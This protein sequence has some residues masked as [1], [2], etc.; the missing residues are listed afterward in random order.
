MAAYASLNILYL[1]VHMKLWDVYSIE[2]YPGPP[3]QSF[4]NLPYTDANIILKNQIIRDAQQL[5]Q[6]HWNEDQ[7]M[8]K[9]LI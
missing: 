7:H 1:V 2:P 4:D 6:K 3:G 5:V 9:V 8:N